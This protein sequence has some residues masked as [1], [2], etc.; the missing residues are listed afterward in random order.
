MILKEWGKNTKQ[1]LKFLR[2][3]ARY[4]RKNQIRTAK[5]TE[6][7]N[8]FN[9]NNKMLKKKHITTE[10][11]HATRGSQA[12]AEQNSD[13]QL[14]REDETQVGD[15][16]DVRT[17][18]LSRVRGSVTNNKGVLDRIIGFISATITI[19]LYYNPL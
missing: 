5:I 9:L 7:L 14:E 13:I 6:Q 11:S 17:K 12:D 15:S 16:L 1:K 10:T 4:T 8:I 18:I 19:T 2:N 3:V